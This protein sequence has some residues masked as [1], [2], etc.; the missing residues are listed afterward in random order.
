[1]IESRKIK[2]AGVALALCF[3]VLV[4]K[5]LREVAAQTAPPIEWGTIPKDSQPSLQAWL[6][7]SLAEYPSQMEK[8]EVE[9]DK[10]SVACE[11]ETRVLLLG[12]I[13]L[14]PRSREK[15]EVCEKLDAARRRLRR[16]EREF[17]A[18]TC[19]R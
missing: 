10:L 19:G 2:L 4:N 5:A 8:M 7:T 13:K 1:M 6:F 17:M 16:A 15:S 3:L 11:T 12:D 9:I 18:R 14:Y